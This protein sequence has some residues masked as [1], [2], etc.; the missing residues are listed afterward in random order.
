M[1]RRARGK[2]RRAATLASTFYLFCTIDRA[3]PPCAAKKRSNLAILDTATTG[4]SFS[5]AARGQNGSSRSSCVTK[6]FFRGRECEQSK[7]LNLNMRSMRGAFQRASSIRRRTIHQSDQSA[8]RRSAGGA[9]K[10]AQSSAK[11]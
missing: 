7:V 3:L 8:E 6:T 1:L 11:C 5:A 4:S 10:C 2:R 9:L